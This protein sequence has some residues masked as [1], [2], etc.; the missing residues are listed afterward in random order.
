MAQ[1]ARCAAQFHEL[2]SDQ[3][4][5]GKG[6][7]EHARDREPDVARSALRGFAEPPADGKGRPPPCCAAQQPKENREDQEIKREKF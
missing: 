2:E 6:S 1:Q 7:D 3:P 5:L 4:D